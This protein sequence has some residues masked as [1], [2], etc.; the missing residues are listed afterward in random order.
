M[1]TMYGNC[2]LD[3][4]VEFDDLANVLAYYEEPGTYDWTPATSP[5]TALSASM[6]WL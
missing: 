3:G 1:A 6:T 5:T 4:Y 2:D